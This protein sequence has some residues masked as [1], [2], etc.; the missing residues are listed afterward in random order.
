MAI[1]AP[2]AFNM[3]TGPAHW[4]TMF[5][6]RAVDNQ[7][8]TIGAAPARDE[9]GPYVSYGHSIVCDPWG[10]VLFQAGPEPVDRVIDID[11]SRPAAVR[12]QLPLLSGERDSIYESILWRNTDV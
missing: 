6:S 10:T 3:T 7:L 9:S 1:I 2:A 12:A 5:R 8:F 4:E 11:L